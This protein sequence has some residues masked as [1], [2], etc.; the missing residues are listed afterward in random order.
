MS[1]NIKITQEELDSLVS[2]RERIRSNVESVGRLNIKKHF[3]ESELA[4]VNADLAEAYA[5]SE[6]LAMEETRV[7][8]EITSK[9]GDGDLNFETGDYIPNQG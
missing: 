5:V 2:L 1:E 4:Q 3:T 8:S 6:D 7:V 9:Y